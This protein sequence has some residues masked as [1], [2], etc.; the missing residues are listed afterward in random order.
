MMYESPVMEIVSFEIEDIITVSGGD[1][2]WSPETP[3]E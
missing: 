2:N 1:P 3:E